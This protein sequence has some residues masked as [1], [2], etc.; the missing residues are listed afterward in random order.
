MRI[1]RNKCGENLIEMR[2]TLLPKKFTET[3]YVYLSAL[4]IDL[5]LNAKTYR[6]T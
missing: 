2:F 1:Y 3:L 5:F 6:I 4:K